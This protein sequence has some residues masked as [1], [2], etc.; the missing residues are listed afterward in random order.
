[1]KVSILLILAFTLLS[2]H[3]QA[4]T[5]THNFTSGPSYANAQFYNLSTDA[6]QSIAHT[7][8]DIAFSVYGF[9]DGGIFINEGSSFSGTAPK[10]YVVP[11]KVFSDVITSADFGSEL[12]NDEKSWSDGAFNS[13]KSPSNFADYGWG[14]YNMTNHKIEG[15]ALYVI[16]LGNGTQKKFM[17]DTLTSGTYYFRYADL[18]GSN[19]ESKSV[20]KSA[21]PNQTLAYFSFATG[22]TTVAEPSTG[23]DWVFTRYE[24]LLHSTN[25]P[26]PYTVGGIL[27]NRNVE[28]VLADN[29]NPSTVSINN[30]TTSSDSLSIIGHDW[31]SFDFQQGWIVDSDRVYFIKGADSS[32]YKIQFIDFRGSST[33]QGSF[34]KT[35]LGMWTSINSIENQVF[36]QFDI[37]PNPATDQVNVTFS[38]LAPQEEVQISLTNMLG[39]IVFQT[40]INGQEGL[41]AAVV[42]TY[43]FN[44]GNYVLT[45]QTPQSIQSRKLVLK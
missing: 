14:A 28:A 21:Y 44:A 29:I 2:G 1:M 12:K 7:D 34:T 19:L 5:T 4:Q 9:T 38:L 41:N 22:R 39:S 20:I 26:T 6:V 35:F 23:W 31:K 25:P 36:E 30:Y 32:L 40:T 37:F 16:E 27:T 13:I 17:I 43:N 33:G 45:I 18:D 15:T 8:W 10:V 11:N 3:S 42:N 24:T